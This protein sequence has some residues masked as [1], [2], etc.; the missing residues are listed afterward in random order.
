MMA[1]VHYYGACETKYTDQPKPDE[2]AWTA[3]C[4]VSMQHASMFHITHAEVIIFGVHYGKSVEK[5]GSRQQKWEKSYRLQITICCFTILLNRCIV[6]QMSCIYCAQYDA[7]SN[8][9]SCCLPSAQDGNI[10]TSRLRW[11]YI[12]LKADRWHDLCLT[13]QFTPQGIA[14]CKRACACEWI[15]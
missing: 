1:T 2:W 8:L 10:G 3:C 14:F 15:S 11:T 4:G 7:H 13:C 12:K 5:S 9:R 6:S